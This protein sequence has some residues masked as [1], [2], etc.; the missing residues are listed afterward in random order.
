MGIKRPEHWGEYTLKRAGQILDTARREY[1]AGRP[2]QAARN[3]RLAFMEA[4]GVEA[5]AKKALHTRLVGVVD[6]Y[7][8][9]NALLKQL[10]A[11]QRE[12]NR[13]G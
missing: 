10:L 13:E 7:E 8:Q 6:S 11:D 3:A 9:T 12:K 4:K 1:A 5:A 2:K